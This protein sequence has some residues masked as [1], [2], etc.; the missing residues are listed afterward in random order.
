M[1]FTN[2]IYIYFL[3]FCCHY[4]VLSLTSS[5]QNSLKTRTKLRTKCSKIV[6]GGGVAEIRGVD[7][8][9]GGK[10]TM[11]VGGIDAPV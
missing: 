2:P 9:F 4:P 10:S 7:M 8:R 11:V 1:C 3:F 5:F 6:Y